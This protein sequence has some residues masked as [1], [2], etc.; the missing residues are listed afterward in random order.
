MTQQNSDLVQIYETA[1]RRARGIITSVKADQMTRPT[2]CSDWDV[3]ELLNHMVRAQA[4]YAGTISG[5]EVLTGKTPLEDFDAAVS[6]ILETVKAPGGLEKMVEG[7]QGEVPASQ[8]LGGACLDLAIHT[9]DLAKATEQDTRLDSEVVGFI[10]PMVEGIAQRGPN[11]AFTT[12]VDMPASAS[13]QD[14]MIALTGRK[15]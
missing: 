7:R 11:R 2:P 14:R 9:W 4:R 8:P 3:T 5:G 12:P 6:A 1:T 10:L 13:V 15:P